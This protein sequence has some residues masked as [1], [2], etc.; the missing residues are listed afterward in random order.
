MNTAKKQWI[1]GMFLVVTLIINTLGA[2]GAIN[3]L[4]Q[5]EISDMYQ[6]LITPSPATF[7][8]WAVIYSLLII[9]IIVMIVKKDDFYYNR[10]A[11]EIT[12]LFRASCILNIG[13]IVCFSYIQI[14]LSVVFIIAL[15]ISLLL[16]C[17]R[18]LRIQEGR[19][20]LLPLTFG[21]YTGWLIIATIVNIAATLVKLQWSGFGI[22]EEVWAVIVLVLASILVIILQINNRNAVLSLPVA[23]AYLGIYQLL[24]KDSGFDGQYGILQI[25][26]LAGMVVLI[27]AAGIRFY[28]NRYSILSK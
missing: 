24:S 2:I 28:K 23:W 4:T 22:G 3:G 21:L 25:V 27:A 7:R 9:A 26:S 12:T 10:A 13:W 15:V 1:N 16:I 17:R 8:I 5:K 20:W 6:T 14:E 11:N 19:R 18:L